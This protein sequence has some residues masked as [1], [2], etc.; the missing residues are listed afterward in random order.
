MNKPNMVHSRRDVVLAIAVLAS[1]MTAFAQTQALN[2][3]EA[4]RSSMDAFAR[5][6]VAIAGKS[7]IPS[8]PK[9]LGP[10]GRLL[11]AVV[12]TNAKGVQ[13][14]VIITNS[15][16]SEFQGE[17]ARHFTGSV[18]W[19][20]IVDSVKTDA[21]RGVHILGVTFPKPKNLEDRIDFPQPHQDRVAIFVT[22]QKIGFADFVFVHI[23]VAKLPDAKL[24]KKGDS[25]AFRG[26]FQKADGDLIGPVFVLYGVG[27]NR[28][29][30]TVALQFTTAEPAD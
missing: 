20:G 14:E 26:V 22:R 21:T 23:P 13:T 3:T 24:P 7:T 6:V 12:I 30:L 5:E 28:G 11:D 8:A 2:S 15:F 18:S 29:R 17:L 10:N 4:W 27:P 9:D 19:T 16:E 25:F 1:L